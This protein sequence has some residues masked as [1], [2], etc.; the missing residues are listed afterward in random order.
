MKNNYPQPCFNG[1]GDIGLKTNCNGAGSDGYH[2][3][4]GTWRINFILKSKEKK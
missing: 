3:G 4:G 2:F 1:G